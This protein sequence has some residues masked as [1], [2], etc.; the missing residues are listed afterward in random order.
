MLT[1]NMD[2]T[3]SIL[4]RTRLNPRALLITLAT[5]VDDITPFAQLLT[6]FPAA[7]VFGFGG[8]L[9][10]NRMEHVLRRR[11]LPFRGAE[12][13]GEHG[14][15]AIRVYPGEES[16][17]EV[18]KEVRGFLRT[19]TSLA[20]ET[21]N[22]S[23][24]TLLAAL[25]RSIIT[26]SGETH[27]LCGRHPAYGIYL[28]WPFAVGRSGIGEPMQVSLAGRA[29]QDLAALVAERSARLPWLIARSGESDRS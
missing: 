17:G 27:N 11:G 13:V 18:A 1:P 20:G 15:N 5:P 26:D 25:L 8:D 4:S 19:V 3:R 29:E 28:T 22:L 10:R 2:I 16:Y 23:T 7:Q 6:G 9:D 12:L 24:A 21:R 14:G